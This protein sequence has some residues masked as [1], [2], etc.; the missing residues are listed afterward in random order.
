M[1]SRRP[2]AWRAGAGG[3]VPPTAAMRRARRDAR[4]TGGV[5]A[6]SGCAV[7]RR[8]CGATGGSGG[9]NCA[10]RDRQ[11]TRRSPWFSFSGTTGRR[12][13]QCTMVAPWSPLSPPFPF[14]RI[15]HGASLRA[16]RLLPEERPGTLKNKPLHGAA[17]RDFHVAPKA[18]EAVHADQ[19]MGRGRDAAH[20]G[21][22]PLIAIR[23][24]LKGKTAAEV[25]AGATP[26]PCHAAP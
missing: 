21:H 26:S 19:R 24:A 8:A 12:A 23:I 15:V 2:A 13:P 17:A 3:A 6:G 5:S 22:N 10:W 4:P 25:R 9:G 20:Q 1:M 11:A 14:L 7:G 16:E 18:F